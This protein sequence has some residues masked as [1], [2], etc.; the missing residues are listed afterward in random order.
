MQK[1]VARELEKGISLIEPDILRV[2]Q[3]VKAKEPVKQDVVME[4]KDLSKDSH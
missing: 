1:T 4:E 3:A 2:N